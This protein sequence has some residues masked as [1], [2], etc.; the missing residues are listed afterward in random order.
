MYIRAP[1]HLELANE[2]LI[3]EVVD[4][5]A[6]AIERG[7]VRDGLQPEQLAVHFLGSLFGLLAGDDARIQSSD[8]IAD[9]DLAVDIFLNGVSR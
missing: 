7:A 5:F 1:M 2:P 3:V 4:Y 6:D 8:G 9:F